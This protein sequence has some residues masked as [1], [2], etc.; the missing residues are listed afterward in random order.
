MQ[1]DALQLCRSQLALPANNLSAIEDATDSEADKVLF[2]L[3]DSLHATEKEEARQTLTEAV[4]SYN[5]EDTPLTYRING[6]QTRWW[7]NDVIEI[8]QVIGEQI[9]GIVLPK[10][11]KP[12]DVQAVETLLKQVEVNAGLNPGQLDL[13][14]QIE[15]ATGMGNVEQIV[16]IGNSRLDAVIFG[17]G[18]YSTSIEAKGQ[19][20]ESNSDY[21]GHYW[22]YPL[23]R[24]SH[25]A[26]SEG[27]LVIDGLYMNVNDL[28]GFQQSCKYAKMLG[29]DGKWVIHPDQTQAANDIFSP[30]R[31]EAERARR[32][33]N[34]H[35]EADEDD[36]PMIDGKMLDER[37]VRMARHIVEKARATGVLE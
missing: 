29:Y 31:E 1:D 16:G 11:R 2:D 5:W 36:I 20:M 6:L 9:D 4:R 19:V 15:D 8:V 14:I 17:P 13:A 30:S 12:A 24:I 28:D 33:V 18:D 3:E 35:Q 32:I 27:L 23:S 21:P 26:A 22:H 10:V 37:T 7:Y 34:I 25:A